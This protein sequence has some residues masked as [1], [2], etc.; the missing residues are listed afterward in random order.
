MPPAFEHT[1]DRPT[2]DKSAYT[3]KNSLSQVEGGYNTAILLALASGVLPLALRE[4]TAAFGH[5]AWAAAGFLFAVG[6]GFS[7]LG[8]PL[9]WHEQFRLE[10]RFGFNTTTQKLWWIDRV[11]GLLLP[12]SSAI[13]SSS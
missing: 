6:L 10:E 11:K 8:L 9:A 1:I 3:A 4:T 13:H 12:C 2:Y 5:S 7:L